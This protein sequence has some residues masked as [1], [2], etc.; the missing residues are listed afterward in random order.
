[1]SVDG[2]RLAL[3]SAL[4]IVTCLPTAVW[5]EEVVRPNEVPTVDDLL[6]TRPSLVP[7]EPPDAPEPASDFPQPCSYYDAVVVRL[8]NQRRELIGAYELY[9]SDKLL[10]KI[11]AAGTAIDDATRTAD[12]CIL[13]RQPSGAQLDREAG[14]RISRSFMWSGRICVFQKQLKDQVKIYEAIRRRGFINLDALQHAHRYRRSIR[15][16]EA[17]VRAQKLTLWSCKDRRVQLLMPCLSRP[18]LP[19]LD[20]SREPYC[21]TMP[22][23]AAVRAHGIEPAMIWADDK[24][25]DM[26][27]TD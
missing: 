4:S 12:E 10:Q 21:R 8:K 26:T 15:D 17:I 6:N 20:G 2:Q 14:S 11:H 7:T 5:G 16:A 18:D 1:M 3:W 27:P 19:H 24:E 13:S 22:Y 25:P 9:G 23:L